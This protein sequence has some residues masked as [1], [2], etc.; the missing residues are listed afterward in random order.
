MS[1]ESTEVKASDAV[2]APVDGVVIR[3][4][5]SF[6]MSKYLKK[7]DL[8]KAKSEYYK[9][10]ADKLELALVEIANIENRYN[11]GDWDEIE[12]AREIAVK[13]LGA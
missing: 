7:E 2:A 12:E 5:P 10:Y 1:N 11:C 6:V 9:E 13:A 3:N 4:H 8:Y